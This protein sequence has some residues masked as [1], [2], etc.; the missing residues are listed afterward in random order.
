M[1]LGQELP[2]DVGDFQI[3]LVEGKR[4]DNFGKLSENL[5]VAGTGD[6]D[7]FMEDGPNGKGN[8]IIGY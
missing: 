5:V 7:F 8:V 3:G 4:F 6:T 2:V 1:H